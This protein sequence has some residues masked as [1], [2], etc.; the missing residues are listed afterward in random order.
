MLSLAG[1]GR[2]GQDRSCWTKLE[3]CHSGGDRADVSPGHT[4]ANHWNYGQLCTTAALLR[5]CVIIQLEHRHSRQ[6][7]VKSFQHF[8]PALGIIL[9]MTIS[10]H[11]WHGA[12]FMISWGYY[13]CHPTS[14]PVPVLTHTIKTVFTVSR[15]QHV[16]RWYSELPL[17][18]VRISIMNV[19]SA[20]QKSLRP[21]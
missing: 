17:E 21:M 15:C 3:L 2:R 19:F 4:T 20:A 12:M 8:Q 5:P 7:T 11:W 9:V 16:I 18:S 14:P 1:A 6:N 13:P 10:G